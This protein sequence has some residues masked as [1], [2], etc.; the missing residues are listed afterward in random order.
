VALPIP[1][2]GRVL[3]YSYLWERENT[4]GRESGAKD[5]PCVIDL[6]RQVRE[7]VTIVTVVAV[8]HTPPSDPADA[9]EIPAKI[10]THLNLDEQRSWIVLTEVNSFV[11]PGPDL[12]VVPGS[13]PPRFDYGVLPPAFFRKLRNELV[14]VIKSRRVQIVARSQ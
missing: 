9:L 6:D 4:A 11:W 5:R 2:P 14:A 13:S 7:G 12:V 10:K 3:R 8:T 1:H